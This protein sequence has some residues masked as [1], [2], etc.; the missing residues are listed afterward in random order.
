MTTR[1]PFEPSAASLERRAVLERVNELLDELGVDGGHR[2]R[3]G[4][5]IAALFPPSRPG[6]SDDDV[7]QAVAATA[8]VQPPAFVE[9][10]ALEPQEDDVA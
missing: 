4:V 6:P 8:P 9:P 2:R 10:P 1:S 3:A 5:R 7:R